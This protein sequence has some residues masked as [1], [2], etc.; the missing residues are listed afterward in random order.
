MKADLENQIKGFQQ[1]MLGIVQQTQMLENELK[2]AR[3]YKIN[4]RMQL[5]D[6]YAKMLKDETTLVYLFFYF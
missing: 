4:Y 2:T 6:L 5:K 3:N 1:E